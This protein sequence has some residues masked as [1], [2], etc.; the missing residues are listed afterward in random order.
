M[1]NSPTI[2]TARGRRLWKTV[3]EFVEFAGNSLWKV[4]WVAF[5]RRFDVAQIPTYGATPLPAGAKAPGPEVAPTESRGPAH[6]GP[7]SFLTLAG[8]RA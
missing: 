7:L 5:N 4:L 2:P 3:T 6:P 1:R 8:G